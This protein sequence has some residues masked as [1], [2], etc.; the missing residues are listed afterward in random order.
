MHSGWTP[1]PKGAGDRAEKASIRCAL[2]PPPTPP[3]KGEGGDRTE[4]TRIATQKARFLRTPPPC[5]E[6]LGVGAATTYA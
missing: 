2:P 6:G 1:R 3:R 5:G 4:T